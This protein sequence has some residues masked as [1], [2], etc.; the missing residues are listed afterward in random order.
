MRSGEF[1]A[2]LCALL[3]E[4]AGL[5]AEQVRDIETTLRAEFGGRDVYVQRYPKRTRLAADAGLPADMPARERAQVLG[6]TEQHAR[7][8]RALRR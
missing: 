5:P 6:V 3:G 8:L 4:R 7:R 2:R 1:M